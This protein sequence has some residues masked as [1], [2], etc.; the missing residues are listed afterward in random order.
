[1]DQSVTPII[2]A[3]ITTIGGVIIALLGLLDRRNGERHRE[4]REDLKGVRAEVKAD[5]SEHLSF[6]EHKPR[7]YVPPQEAA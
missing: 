2:V 1:M 6:Y 4:L 3:S 7:L 5:L